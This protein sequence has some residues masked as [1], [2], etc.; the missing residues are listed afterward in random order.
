MRLI[1]LLIMSEAVPTGTRSRILRCLGVDLGEE[2]F[3]ASRVML[4]SR[5]LRTGRGC[6]I[7][8]G[9]HFD[10]GPITLG[11]KVFIG[12]GA[13]FISNDHVLGG[14]TQRA[15]HNIEKPISVGDGSWI[16]ARA[17]ILGGVH[18]AA[19]C[20]IG[21]GAVVTRDTTPNGVYVGVPARRIMDL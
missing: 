12:P 17:I 20:V 11:S 1:N 21:A 2:T 8:H 10:R 9:V 7:N 16:G 13:L 18:I 15:G 14:P 3:I 6:F 4:K 19:G 5:S